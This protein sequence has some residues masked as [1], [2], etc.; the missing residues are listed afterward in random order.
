MLPMADIIPPET[1]VLTQ[2]P[3]T[4]YCG[5]CGALVAPPLPVEPL[6]DMQVVPALIPCGFGGLVSHLKRHDAAHRPRRYRFD[7]DRRKHRVLT[8]TEVRMIRSRMLQERW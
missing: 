2:P 6:Y 3:A 4:F 5:S 1:P 7:S 8:A